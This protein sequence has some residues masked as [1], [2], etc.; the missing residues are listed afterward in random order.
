MGRVDVY[1]NSRFAGVLAQER[2]EQVFSYSADA[3]EALSLT[4]PLRTESYTQRTLHPCF[5]MNLP[6]GHLREAI[7]RATAKQFGS[8]DLTLL[9]LLGNCQLGRLGFA[10]AGAPLLSA[11]DELPDLQQLLADD[12]ADLFDQL[13]TRYALRS[14]VAGVQPKVLLDAL[15]PTLERKANLAYKKYIVKSWGPEFPEL[16]SNE[17]F[18]LSL[19]R[20]AGLPVPDFHLSENGKLLVIERFDVDEQ[21]RPLG[22]E[23]FCVLQG[24]G[25]REKYDAS[26]ESCTRTIRQ[27]VS[28]EHQRRALADFFLLTL[29]NVRLRNGDGHL[30]N[31]GILYPDLQ[32][33]R[34]GE[35]P[36]VERVM[37]PV[38]DIVNTT[39]Y[40]PQDTMALTLVGTKR[41]PRWRFLSDFGRQHCDLKLQEIDRLAEQVDKACAETSPLLDS[42]ADRFPDFEPVADVLRSCLSNR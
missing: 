30:K 13:L 37:A 12:R 24:K 8:D 25:T 32:G 10:A 18:C 7:E 35:W 29:V 28:P 19:A 11:E 1:V 17:Y 31:S 20:N 21:L 23:D 4:M 14:G 16:A 15:P 6:E 40:I 9:T 2:G 33:L 34:Q 41:W 39:A 36:R 42:L 22:F 5:Q 27:F 26:L 38:Y 3:G